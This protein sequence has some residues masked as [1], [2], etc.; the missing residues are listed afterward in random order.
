[1]GFWTCRRDG[2]NYPD[3]DPEV[4]ATPVYVRGSPTLTEIWRA[5]GIQE[6]DSR[7]ESEEI[8]YDCYLVVKM[9]F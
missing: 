8:P 6:E 3:G 5:E 1:M 2:A 4:M 9:V 7:C